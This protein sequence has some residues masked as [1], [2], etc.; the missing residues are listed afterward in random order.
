MSRLR[1]AQHAV[2]ARLGPRGTLWLRNAALGLGGLVGA[3]LLALVLAAAWYWSDL[4]P[5]TKATDYRPQQHLQVFTSDGVEIAQFGAERRVFVPIAEVP[6]ALKDAILATEDAQFYEHGGISFRGLVRATIANISGGM[7]QGASTITQQVARTFFLS[8]RRTPERKIKEALLA[9]QLERRL[10]KDQI[11]E[12]YLNQIF[13]GQ[14]AYGFGAAA[15]VYFGKPLSEVDLAEAAL[16]AGLPQN[17]VYANPVASLPRAVKRQH[18]VLQRMVKTAMITE[19]ERDAAMARPLQIRAPHAVDVHAEHV[20]EMARRA[21]V[22]RLGDKAYTEGVRVVTTLRADDQRAAHAAL[23]RTVLAHERKQPWRGPEDH[24]DLPA[25]A[26]AADRAAAL[27]LKDQR[28]DEDLRVAIVLAATPRELTL[29]LASGETIAVNPESGPRGAVAAIGPKA[30]ANLALRRGAIVRVLQTAEGGR[31][32]RG[33]AT[34]AEWQL[35]QWPEAE[36]GFV[37]L[38]PATGRIRALVGGFDFNHRQFNHATQAARQPGSAFKPFLYSAAFEHGVMPET[39]V[40]DAPMP[41]DADG[42]PPAWNPGNSDGRF[43]GEMTVREALVR[44]KNLVSIRLLRQVGVQ[45]VREWAQRFGFAPADLPANLTLALGSGS[46]TPLQLAGA[47]AVFANGGHRVSPVLVERI[48]TAGGEVLYQAAPPPVLD[49]STRVVPAR[50]VFLVNSLMADV[51]RRGTAARAQGT[52]GRGDLY[53]KTGTTN[54]AVDAWFGGHAPG[55]AAVAWMGYPEPR[56]L[57]E[58]ESGGGLALPIW[59]DAM[60]SMLRGVR[61]QAPVVP[62]GLL[63]VPGADWRYAEFADGGAVLRIGDQAA[64]TAPAAGASAP[65]N[66]AAAAPAPAPAPPPRL[67]DPAAAPGVLPPPTAAGSQPSR[68][69]QITSWEAGPPPGR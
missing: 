44:S 53:G 51:T 23:R 28:D 52:L 42:S 8:T 16:L 31:D 65:A 26:E 34:A 13:L 38:D 69:P 3:F 7:P 55:V 43:D 19:A 39:V 49:G 2:A 46:A 54:D 21:V 37:A 56:S 40:L 41:A 35:V 12:L 32:A 1:S 4:P 45:P 9:L 64:V 14:R 62:E 17:P 57:G 58:G 29:R 60:K 18:W 10:S 15:Q 6:K 11:L 59:I 36:A 24:E 61:E 50:N 22:E 67:P 66:G 68:A 33:R 27:A 5:L 30:P 20:A 63:F 47:Y 25:E 48:V